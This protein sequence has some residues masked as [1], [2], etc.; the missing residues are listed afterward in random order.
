MSSALYIFRLAWPFLKELVLGGL[1]LKEG[2]RTHKRRV[3]LL[4]FV[5]GLL[6]LLILLIPRFYVLN[7]DHTRLQKSVEATNVSRLESRIKELEDKLFKTPSGDS[8]AVQVAGK[9]KEPEAPPPPPSPPPQETK[10]VKADEPS[11]VSTIRTHSAPQKKRDVGTTDRKK[12]YMEF[13]DQY[14][15]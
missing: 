15:D 8:N 5:S 10:V 7:Q 11:H 12:S 6:G 13:F 9:E 4:F 1:T 14:D 2:M 3:A